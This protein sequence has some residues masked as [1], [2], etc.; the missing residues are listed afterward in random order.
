MILFEIR[1]SHKKYNYIFISLNFYNDKIRS[2]YQGLHAQMNPKSILK[3]KY[4]IFSIQMS[5][6]GNN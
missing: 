2:F 3:N 4:S 5:L 1:I 6:F